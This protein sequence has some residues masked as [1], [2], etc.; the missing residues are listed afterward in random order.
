MDG[1]V[2]QIIDVVDKRQS[3]ERYDRIA[4]IKQFGERIANASGQSCNFEL[5]VLQEK[6]GGNGPIMGNALAR[7]GFPLTYIGPL[8]LEKVHR[9]FGDFARRATVI[10]L[11]NPANTRALEF[12][13]G[14]VMLGD[15]GPL[16][17]VTWPHILAT[18]GR[19]RLVSIMN[20]SSLLGLLNWTMLPHMT[21]IWRGFAAD[22]LPRL[23]KKDRFLFVDLADPEKRL[24]EDLQG[25]LG[26]LREINPHVHVILGLNLSEAHQVARALR[27]SIIHNEKQFADPEALAS[28]IQR[29]LQIGTVVVHPRMGA[30]A[31]TAARAATFTG[32]FVASPKI[33]TGAGDHFN[34]GFAAGRVLGMSL[35]ESLGARGGGQR[36]LCTTRGKPDGGATGGVS[37]R[38]A[39]AAGPD[40]DGKH[41]PLES[42]FSL[43]SKDVHGNH[44]FEHRDVIQESIVE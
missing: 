8:G 3:V 34:A 36:L 14:K 9:V 21:S 10:S 17:E 44:H 33:S 11:A 24:V 5:V 13:D 1:F 2:D 40:A 16:S 32:P 43:S 19:E 38:S 30:S 4:T 15:L 29:D 20:E 39:I 23:S 12:V 7:L 37:V 22:I 27:L 41:E 35:E 18:V 28:A 26:T 6:L 31:A 25:A 42:L